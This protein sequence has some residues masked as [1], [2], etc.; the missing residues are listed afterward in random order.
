MKPMSVFALAETKPISRNIVLP[1][2]SHTNLLLLFLSCPLW[3]K[4]P[5]L[6]NYPFP[7]SHGPLPA[8][9]SQTPPRHRRFVENKRR[10][11]IRK[12]CRKAVDPSFSRFS[13]LSN[14]VV[15]ALSPSV[16]CNSYYLPTYS[17]TNT[18]R[19]VSKHSAIM[20]EYKANSE[21]IWRF[22][23]NT[24]ILFCHSNHTVGAPSF[25]S[26]GPARDIP[27]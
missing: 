13:R 22:L 10:T 18:R 20:S 12:A 25:A 5:L 24:R 8:S 21:F 2:I 7:D 16:T 6:S 26:H 19:I 23:A 3:F 17:P 9:L 1:P 4:C 15:S 27:S 14:H 11:P